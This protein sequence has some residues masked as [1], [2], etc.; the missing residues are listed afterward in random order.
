MAGIDEDEM[1][2]R[3]L[4]VL[5][6]REAASRVLE[7][8]KRLDHMEREMGD[9]ERNMAQQRAEQERDFEEKTEEFQ[10]TNDDLKQRLASIENYWK[11][12]GK[13]GLALLI[14]AIGYL[15]TIVFAFIK[16]RLTGKMEP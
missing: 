2:R 15:A 14:P 7:L 16:Y 12:G 5:D 8:Q 4:R 13:I 10:K 3:L 11:L 9:M 6:A 1:E